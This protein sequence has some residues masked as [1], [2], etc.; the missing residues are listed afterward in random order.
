M[1]KNPFQTPHMAVRDGDT[2]FT[3]VVAFLERCDSAAG[4]DVEADPTAVTTV[5]APTTTD[6][7]SMSCVREG[8]LGWTVAS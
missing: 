7:E 1:R 2:V 6:A 8:K 4:W 3:S 5:T